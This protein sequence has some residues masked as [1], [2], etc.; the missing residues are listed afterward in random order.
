MPAEVSGPRPAPSGR[1]PARVLACSASALP[2]A[3][4][5]AKAVSDYVRT[6]RN[7]LFVQGAYLEGQVFPASEVTELANLPS[8]EAMIAQFAGA[9]QSPLVTFAGLLTSVVRE[10]AGLVDARVQQ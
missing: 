3:A 8:K 7:A 2:A 5:A 9:M 6:A 10:F 1:P 4:V